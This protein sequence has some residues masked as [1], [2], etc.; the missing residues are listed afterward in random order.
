VRVTTQIPDAGSPVKS[1]LPVTNEQFVC[2]TGPITGAK[3]AGNI[4]IISDAF[5]GPHP[6]DAGTV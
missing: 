2:V 1:T 5:A 4:V 6:P 3:G